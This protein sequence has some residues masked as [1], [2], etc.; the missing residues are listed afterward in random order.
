MIGFSINLTDDMDYI[1]SYIKD[2][3]K[4]GF[5]YVFGTIYEPGENK[6]T[7]LEKVNEV[8]KVCQDLGMEFSLGI[9]P[10]SAREVGLDLKPE[11]F[12]AKHIDGIRVSPSI[13]KELIADFSKHMRVGISATHKNE[14]DIEEIKALGG[15]LSNIRA[16]FHYYERE[17]IGVSDK[18]LRTRVDYWKDLGIRT[19]AFVPG[20]DDMSG[21]F[22]PRLTLEVH[23]NKHP[24]YAT[25]DL[26]KNFGVDNVYIGDSMLTDKTIDQFGQYMEEKTIVY[27]VDVLD[28]EY[29]DLIKGCHTNRIDEAEGVIRATDPIDI[30]GMK[31]LDRFLISRPKGSLTLDN[32]RNGR[33]MGEFHISKVDLDLR[34]EVNVVAHVREE[35]MNLID[36]CHGGDRFEIRENLE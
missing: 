6:E 26:I 17:E 24:L 3:E 23:R 30:K 11:V 22:L 2:M 9:S 1:V 12:I 36:I 10:G 31:I 21:E 27:Y 33:F 8:G 7:F 35:D 18:Y 5:I 32:H 13:S 19:S 28:Q 20:D 25:I 34:P 16:W 4:A 15:K 29:F 14:E